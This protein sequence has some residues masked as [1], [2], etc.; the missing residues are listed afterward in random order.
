MFRDGACKTCKCVSLRR[1]RGIYWVL[2]SNAQWGAPGVHMRIDLSVD[3]DLES[4]ANRTELESSGVIT[5]PQ[6]H[7][8]SWISGLGSQVLG[9]L[10]LIDIKHV[11]W[12]VKMY[13][14]NKVPERKRR[15]FGF[16]PHGGIFLD[17]IIKT[18]KEWRTWKSVKRMV[19]TL[20]GEQAVNKRTVDNS[21]LACYGDL[22]CVGASGDT[23]AIKSRAGTDY[24][25]GPLTRSPH[26]SGR[27]L[28][29]VD[30]RCLMPDPRLVI[31]DSRLVTRV[32]AAIRKRDCTPID[33]SHC[34][35]KA[36]G[37]YG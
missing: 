32:D 20:H 28:L 33:R 37:K 13:R 17:I 23:G 15:R 10:I 9:L 1:V 19:S 3:S 12:S 11:M 7:A 21:H 35:P 16:Y 6:G 36:V 26:P 22:H 4:E 30:G 31:G 5:R 29:T 8:M 34:S 27:R 14:R 18:T 25:G 24:R 2:G